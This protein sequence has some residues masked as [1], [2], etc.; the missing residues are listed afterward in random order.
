MMRPVT[1]WKLC[2]GSEVKN[3]ARPTHFSLCLICTG[4]IG[5]N[6]C[7]ANALV[8]QHYSKSS[9]FRTG[10]RFADVDC[11][12]CP[13]YRWSSSGYSQHRSKENPKPDSSVC[14]DSVGWLLFPSAFPTATAS[15]SFTRRNILQSLS[16][17]L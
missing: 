6:L 10:V 16:G 2:D 17:R 15:T 14:A 11:G 5:S 7:D 8:G 1:I 13:G 3:S 9:T 12:D 4:G